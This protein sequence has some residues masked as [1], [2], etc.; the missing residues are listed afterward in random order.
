MYHFKSIKQSSHNIEELSKIKIRLYHKCQ[1]WGLLHKK[2]DLRADTVTYWWINRKQQSKLI[3]RLVILNVKVGEILCSPLLQWQKNANLHLDSCKP[4]LTH[5]LLVN[6]T[7]KHN[8]YWLCNRTLLYSKHVSKWVWKTI[9]SGYLR[10]AREGSPN[11]MGERAVDRGHVCKLS[12][13]KVLRQRGERV[14][15]GPTELNSG[16][17]SML[18]A[19]WETT[20]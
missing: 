1:N 17:W 18:Y 7:N 8:G 14:Q 9:K 12:S 20:Y 3:I 10:L 13:A 5:P 2:V 11:K 16:N 15:G 19:V 4:R 6:H